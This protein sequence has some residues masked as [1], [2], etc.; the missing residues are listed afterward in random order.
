MGG[1]GERQEWKGKREGEGE[2]GRRGRRERQEAVVGE[3]R[4]EASAP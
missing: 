1:G 2:E 3:E 4:K